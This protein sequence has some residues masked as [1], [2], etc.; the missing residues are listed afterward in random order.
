MRNAP[1]RALGEAKTSRF[2]CSLALR[3]GRRIRL[4]SREAGFRSYSRTIAAPNE[5]TGMP[6]P[7]FA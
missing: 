4:A 3:G 7:S 6:V 5:G 1:H 2:P